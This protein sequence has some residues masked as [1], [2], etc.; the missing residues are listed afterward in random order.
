MNRQPEFAI[1]DFRSSS[2]HNSSLSVYGQTKTSKIPRFSRRHFSILG[3][4]LALLLAGCEANKTIKGVAVFSNEVQEKLSSIG[5]SLSKDIVQSCKRTKAQEFQISEELF[6]IDPKSG[7]RVFILDQQ[8]EALCLTDTATSATK[9][10]EA[11][12]R[13]ITEYIAVLGKLAGADLPVFDSQ[14]KALVPALQGMPNL[15]DE[16]SK[17]TVDAGGALA[18]ILFRVFGEGFQ[19]AKLAST[20]ESSDAPL[21]TIVTSYANSIKEHYMNGLLAS[22]MISVNAF[23]GIPLSNSIKPT[24]SPVLIGI[25][26]FITVS[27]TRLF[28]SER[29]EVGKRSR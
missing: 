25:N 14:A 22:E 3:G 11:S 9:S 26:P 19:K 5:F 18:R 8:I 4:M 7:K 28:L 12:H 17:A 2:T 16:Q 6:P 21:R 1:H 13:L 29:Q 15:S 27:L 20:M 24:T 23:Y 10:Y